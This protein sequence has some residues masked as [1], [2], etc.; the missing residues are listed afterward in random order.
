MPETLTPPP[1]S[2]DLAE[3]ELVIREAQRRQR[4]RRLAWLSGFFL[5]VIAVAGLV[6]AT[7]GS[8]PTTHPTPAPSRIGAPRPATIPLG[9]SVALHSPGPLAVSQSN[10][11]YVV[12]ASQ[13][14]VIAR[15]AGGE[16]YDVA[17][18]GTSGFSGDGG[19]AVKAQLSSV[20]DIAFAPNGDLYIADGG[21]VRAIDGNGII[22]AVVGDGLSGGRVLPGTPAQSAHLGTVQA[23]AFS[24]NGQLY[25]ATSRQIL[26]MSAAGL[27]EPVKALITTG[28]AKGT[29]LTEFSSIAVAANGNVFVSTASTGWSVYRITAGRATYVG[30]ARRSGGNPAVLQRGA[31]G[32]IVADDGPNLLVV[33]GNRLVTMWSVNQ[34]PG[35]SNFIFMNYFAVTPGGGIDADNLGPGLDRYQQIVQV[36]VGHGYSMW[37]GPSLRTGS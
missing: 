30:Y 16:F 7:S 4:R 26:R 11:L 28:P 8:S 33:R 20:S 12:D 31:G 34:V 13:H 22:Y 25:I 5:L 36:S 37:T 17:G 2:P 35:I 21:R 29:S 3:P 18:N 32:Q 1:R 10:L 15:L 19:P 24:P 6:V 23:I 14:R 27:L 9:S